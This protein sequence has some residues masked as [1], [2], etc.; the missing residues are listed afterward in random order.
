MAACLKSRARF[1]AS[2][3]SPRSSTLTL[4]AVPA[5]HTGIW[6]S[7]YCM[8][9]SMNAKLRDLVL[10][11]KSTDAPYPWSRARHR[12]SCGRRKESGF[13]TERCDCVLLVDDSR[14]VARPL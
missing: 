9:L 10:S 4:S 6:Q 12:I 5:D 7:T 3:N 1:G 11:T 8:L 2:N 13:G 14:A